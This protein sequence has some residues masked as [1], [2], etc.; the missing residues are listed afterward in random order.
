MLVW[1]TIRG[2]DVYPFSHYPMFS[3]RGSIEKAEIFRLALETADNEVYWWKSEFYRYPEYVGR[4]LR[5]L[6]RA[7]KRFDNPNPFIELKKRQFLV[8]V[9][10]LI[11]TENKTIENLQAIRIVKRNIAEK[12]QNLI[13]NDEIIDVFAVSEI[14]K[15]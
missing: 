6:Y 5:E 2:R 9:L 14:I 3:N 1:A 4:K 7:E 15:N 10:R 11:K 12:N 13:I 8:E